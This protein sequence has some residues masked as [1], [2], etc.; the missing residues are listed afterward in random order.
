MKLDFLELH[1]GVFWLL[2]EAL[3]LI[4]FQMAVFLT[5]YRSIATYGKTQTIGA[6]IALTRT[7]IKNNYFLFY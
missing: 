2:F 1:V 4:N 5:A 6:N 7:R 3:Q